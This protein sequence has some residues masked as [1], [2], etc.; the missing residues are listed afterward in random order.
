MQKEEQ[1][2]ILGR[3]RNESGVFGIQPVCVCVQEIMLKN[4]LISMYLTSAGNQ[5]KE[6]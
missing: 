3:N 2:N 5:K 4:T 1:H 6:F